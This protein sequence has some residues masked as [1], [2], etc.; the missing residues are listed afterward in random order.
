MVPVG[1]GVVQS[2]ARLV[3]A[4]MAD[5]AEVTGVLRMLGRSC[6]AL[7]T[8][9]RT[10]GIP[11]RPGD[12][13]PRLWACGAAD[14]RAPDQ[15]AA[16]DAS[17]LLA[18]PRLQLMELAIGVCWFTACSSVVWPR[19]PTRMTLDQARPFGYACDRALRVECC[20]LVCVPGSRPDGP[21]DP[22]SPGRVVQF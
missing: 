10:N 21:H 20:L 7:E 1:H 2:A 5:D 16:L 13:Q 15:I 11:A 12:P 18:V 3:A 17:R 22:T 14:H 4:G 9:E 6:V 19:S 8:G